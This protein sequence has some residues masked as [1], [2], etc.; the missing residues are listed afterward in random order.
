MWHLQ[1][2]VWKCIPVYSSKCVGGAT[3]PAGDAAA[4]LPM[5]QDPWQCLL[6]CM[7][8]SSKLSGLPAI[9]FTACEI[10]HTVS[11]SSYQR[12]VERHVA[13]AH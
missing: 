12:L 4:V 2:K 8:A 3:W 7:L 5:M 6:F 1:L 11:Y 13:V 9:F 10:F